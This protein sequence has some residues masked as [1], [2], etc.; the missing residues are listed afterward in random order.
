MET[1]LTVKVLFLSCAI[2]SS[3]YTSQRELTNYQ[4]KIYLQNVQ[5]MDKKTKRVHNAIKS[6]RK[7]DMDRIQIVNRGGARDLQVRERL[8]LQIFGHGSVDLIPWF[9]SLPYQQREGLFLHLSM[10]GNSK[11][12]VLTFPF[13]TSI[14]IKPFPS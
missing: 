2:I 6:L 3:S 7:S 4:A 1:P 11:C 13:L 12:L 5:A 9:D 10:L 14:R 8:T